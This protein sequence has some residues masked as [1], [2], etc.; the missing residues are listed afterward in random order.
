MTAANEERISKFQTKIEKEFQDPDGLGKIWMYW[1]VIPKDST[2]DMIKPSSEL[3]AWLDPNK[4]RYGFDHLLMPP[5]RPAPFL[6]GLVAS[7]EFR[8]VADG[9]KDVGRLMKIYRNGTIAFGMDLRDDIIPGLSVSEYTMLFLSFAADLLKKI[10]YP[11]VVRV[12]F[13]INK[14]KGTRLAYAFQPFG[15]PTYEE[16]SLEI[17]RELPMDKPSDLAR[18]LLDQLFN[19]FELVRCNFFDKEGKWTGKWTE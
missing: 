19:A 12:V 7:D 4:R 15:Y 10:N 17:V 5:T 2:E 16:E 18:T 6:D 1:I 9:K 11:G 13:G 14:P 8:R 3:I